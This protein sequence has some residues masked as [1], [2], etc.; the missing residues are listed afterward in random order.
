MCKTKTVDQEVPREF[1]VLAESELKQRT[2]KST[3][4]DSEPFSLIHL[5]AE[6]L[7]LVGVV[8]VVDIN[9]HVVRAC[10]KP[11]LA[12]DELDETETAA[13]F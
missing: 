2:V 5:Q 9:V 12:C 3:Y 10:D 11:S 6:H 8:V 1:P 7:D 4:L 13:R